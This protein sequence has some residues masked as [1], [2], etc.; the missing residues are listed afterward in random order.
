VTKVSLPSQMPPKRAKLYWPYVLLG[1]T[2][3]TWSGFWYFAA[4]KTENLMDSWLQRE[5]QLGRIWS[6]LDRQISGYPFRIEIKCNEPQF[7]GQLGG[8][9]Y[10]GT[11]KSLHSFAQVYQPSLVLTD[12]E[13]PLQLKSESGTVDFRMEWKSLRASLQG[14]PTSFK[15]FSVSIVEPK[16]QAESLRGSLPLTKAKEVEFHLRPDGTGVAQ[17]F[18][19]ALSLDGL[20]HP[21]LDDLTGSTEALKINAKGNV[22][23]LDP[24]QKGNVAERLEHWRSSGGTLQAL[25][26][27]IEKSDLNIS[28]KGD[29]KLDE[30]HRP[31]GNLNA[32]FA[33]FSPLLRR[34]GINIPGGA[35]SDFLGGLLGQKPVDKGEGNAR[36]PLRLP[37]ILANGRLFVGPF[38]TPV[39]LQPLYD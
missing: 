3:V 5:A 25:D 23:Q 13:G 14:L 6:C 4:N 20:T 7:K 28:A 24:S 9:S 12:L 17:A 34:F 16:V 37:V 18:D 39:A 11:L 36:K 1:L 2:V 38:K 35:A 22:T 27:K 30:W 8:E 32:E 31:S 29:L 15:R 21:A 10:T 26:M 19:F 33:G